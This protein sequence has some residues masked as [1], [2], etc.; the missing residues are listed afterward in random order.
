MFD[1]ILVAVDETDISKQAFHEAVTF[2]QLMKAQL[3]LV[4][5][6]SPFEAGFPIRVF[7]YNSAFPEVSA[8]A[9][10][11]RMQSW[12]ASEKRG[13]QLLQGLAEQAIAVGVA[14]EFSQPLGNPGQTI[15]ELAKT[16]GAQLIVV[17]RRGRTGLEEAIAGSVSNYVVHHAHC[18]VLTVQGKANPA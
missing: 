1:K 8:E 6:Q 14:A 17:G 18:P 2:G 16:W 13:H 5:V 11:A 12:E 15:C 7:S 9:F 4:H 3:L 10:G